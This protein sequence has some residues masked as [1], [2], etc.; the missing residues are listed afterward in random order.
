MRSL[1][2]ARMTL[3]TILVVRTTTLVNALPFPLARVAG[4]VLGWPL[5]GWPFA[6]AGFTLPPGVRMGACVVQVAAAI[7]FTVGLRARE[8][9]ILA[10]LTGIV[11]LSQEPLAFIYTLPTMFLGVL[12]LALGDGAHQWAL[13]PAPAVGASSSAA[14]VRVLLVTVYLASAVAKVQAPWLSGETLRALAEDGLMT[15]PVAAL[16][17]HDVVRL[18][19]AWLVMIAEGLAA[20]GLLIPRTRQGARLGALALHGAFEVAVRPDVMGLVMGALLVG[21]APCPWAVRRHPQGA[22]S[23]GRD[24]ISRSG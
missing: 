13:V 3:G 14:L 12:V 18:G 9:G 4:P 8:A 10:A 2:V 20:L 24:G 11:A 17:Q 1:A 19:A 6:W 15:A 7:A 5:R 23:D 22:R 21:A 16:L